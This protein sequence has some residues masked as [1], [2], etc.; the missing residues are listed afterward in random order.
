MLGRSIPIRLSPK[1]IFVILA[2]A[3][4]EGANFVTILR[5]SSSTFSIVAAFPPLRIFWEYIVIL[6]MIQKKSFPEQGNVSNPLPAEPFDPHFAK[7]AQYSG[8]F[9]SSLKAM[10][11]A[12]LFPI[13]SCDSA[14]RKK[15][16]SRLAGGGSSCLHSAPLL[17]SPARFDPVAVFDPVGTVFELCASHGKMSPRG[18]DQ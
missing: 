2:C 9:P 8:S 11:D 15:S 14:S 1:N 17:R 5:F 16:I 10:D 7:R 6:T 13:D 18:Q 4:L 12:G 3:K